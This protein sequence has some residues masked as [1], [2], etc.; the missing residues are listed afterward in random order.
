M[1]ISLSSPRLKFHLV[2][3][4]D[5]FEIHELHSLPETD[6]FNTLGIPLDL[7]QTN[8]ILLAWMASAKSDLT[9]EYTFTIRHKKTNAFIG[10][11]ALKCGNP[12]FRIAEV[13][14]KLHVK[15][16]QKGYGTEALTRVL[17]FG[18]EDLKL[19]RIEAGSAVENIASIRVLEKTG[20]QK[21]GRK[22]KTLPLKSGWSD[23]YE[24]AILE[25]DWQK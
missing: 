10:L 23:N 12:K 18:F 20:M 22:R 2:K 7:E 9:P 25:E 21:E 24:F 6:R 16:W 5:L 4:D 17:R 1:D 3:P 19:H 11:I 15:Q 14:Y 8:E 13:W